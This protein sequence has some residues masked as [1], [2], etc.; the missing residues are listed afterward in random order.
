[1][2]TLDQMI[3]SLSPERREKIAERT[4]QLIAEE[5]ALRRMREARGLTQVRL[6]E[7]MHIRQDSVSR[8]ESRS[9]L[10][11]STLKSYVHAMGGSLRLTVEFPDG[12]AAELSSLGEPEPDR[13]PSP[14]PRVSPAYSRSYQPALTFHGR[15]AR[16]EN[17]R[18]RPKPPARPD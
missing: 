9:D 18:G 2:K 4:K 14:R 11:L 10:L 13:E 16:R 5:N 8:L 7:L 15:L 17:E 12:V 3:G 6:A 1:M